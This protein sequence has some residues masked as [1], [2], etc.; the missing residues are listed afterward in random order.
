MPAALLPSQF[1]TL[2]EP[3]AAI[4]VDIREPVEEQVAAIARAL[5]NRLPA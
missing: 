1:A 4:V 3:Q 2:E 5:T